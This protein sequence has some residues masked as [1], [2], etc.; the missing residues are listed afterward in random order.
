MGVS[1]AG[2]R[3]GTVGGQAGREG[4]GASVGQGDPGRAVGTTIRQMGHGFVGLGG[5]P[6]DLND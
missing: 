5:S 3:A 6:P 4:G 2:V 1:R